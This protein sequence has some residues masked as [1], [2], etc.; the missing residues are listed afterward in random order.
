MHRILKN[1]ESIT[2]VIFST[3]SFGF[4]EESLLAAIIQL[5]IIHLYC[6]TILANRTS[7]K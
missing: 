2:N 6:K 1:N 5:V 4:L 3:V 7:E